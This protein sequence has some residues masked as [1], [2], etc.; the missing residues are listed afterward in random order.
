MIS[1]DIMNSYTVGLLL[2]IV[3]NQYQLFKIYDVY[4]NG[5]KTREL[6]ADV[7]LVTI[8]KA[9][10]FLNFFVEVVNFM[11]TLSVFLNRLPLNDREFIL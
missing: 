3:T 8:P 11:S 5:K 9:N 2:A 6:R 7:A 1:F 4:N 10:F